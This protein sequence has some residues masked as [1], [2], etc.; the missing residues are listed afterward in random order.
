MN[1][2]DNNLLKKIKKLRELERRTQCQII[3]HLEEVHKRRLYADLGYSSLFKYMVKE[4]G[5]SEGAAGRRLGA[6]RLSQKTPMAKKMI[7]TGELSL[8]VASD[9]FR[10]CK[11]MNKSSTKKVLGKLKNK[12][13]DEAKLEFL[14]IT[15]SDSAEKREVRQRVSTVATR[16]HLNLANSTISKL[17]KVKAIKKLST[18]DVLEYLLDKELDELSSD[19]FKIKK[20]R[21]SKGR[22]IPTSV[23]KQVKARAE[24]KCE[25]PGCN[26]I[27][28]LE[29]EHIIPYAK[30]GTH[31]LENILLYCKT[32]N[33]RAAIKE[34]GLHKMNR[35]F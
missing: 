14:K 7:E 12:S 22:N 2:S 33:Q 30:G 26:E 4:L 16:I 6:L 17:E 28:N 1:L 34:F 8:S 19:L 25:F 3:A 29:F 11:A 20:S 35:Y 31:E 15:P 9:A 21:G 24:F 27:H 10:F 23:K 5:Y 13:K 32:H 18:E